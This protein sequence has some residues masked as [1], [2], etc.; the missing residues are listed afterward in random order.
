MK[1]IT[2]REKDILQL[3]AQGMSTRQIADV[4]H[5]S[6]HTVQTHRKSL[7]KKYDVANSAELVSKA[8]EIN[9]WNFGNDSL[10]HFEEPKQ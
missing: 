2:S 5:M 10:P 9:N 7:L 8:H 3:I 1:P 6:F 4:L